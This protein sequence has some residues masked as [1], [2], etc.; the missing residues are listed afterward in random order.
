MV[1]VMSLEGIET[2]KEFLKSM[3]EYDVVMSLEG[4]ETDTS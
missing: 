1:V 3:E 2:V 4:I